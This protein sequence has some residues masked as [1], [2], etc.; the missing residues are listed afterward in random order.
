MM[1]RR[2][3]LAAPALL[4]AQ[5]RADRI[6]VA[7]IGAGN[8]GAFLLEH[9]L[10]LEGA[11]V[12]AVCD[13][14]P[15]RADAAATAVAKKGGAA[16]TFTDYRRMLDEVR[17]LDAVIQAAPDY[18]H[19]EID[20]AVLERGKHLYAEKPLALTVEDCRAVRDAA[21]RAPVIM[22]V[23]FQLRHDP[24]RAA[25]MRWIHEGK[26][27]R[28]LQCHGMRHG[29]DLPRNIPW[30]F[31]KTKCGDIVVDQGIHILDL[32]RWAIGKPPLRCYGDGGTTLFVDTPP[33]RTV[34]DHYSLIYEFEGG[35]QINFSH[36]YFDPPGFTGIQER[37]FLSEGAVDLIRAEFQPRTERQ[38]VKLE[39][40]GAGQDATRMSLAAFLDNVR[41]RRRPLN[42]V[43]SAF[44]A[45]LVALMGTRSIYE[46]RVVTWDEMNA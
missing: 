37:V 31:D 26:A 36:H 41:N 22:Q 33:G 2:A 6:R 40:P 16:R 1:T 5:N 17:E 21:R 28:V 29:G 44:E 30:Y 24:A 46:K 4:R 15:E 3:M 23:G 34:M 7:L 10:E 42:D 39:V 25:A 9:L 38:R 12:V 43:D 32:F 19:R 11:E 18:T 35:V 14:L 20:I 45:T 27:G 8:R 13:I